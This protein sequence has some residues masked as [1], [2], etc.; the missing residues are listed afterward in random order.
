M[1]G[2][3]SLTSRFNILSQNVQGLTPGKEDIMLEL[4]DQL[5]LDLLFTQETFRQPVQGS[6]T[7]SVQFMS[8]AG[9]SILE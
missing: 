4:M 9:Y 6:D 5:H 3:Q 8:R 7:Q 2:K 1:N